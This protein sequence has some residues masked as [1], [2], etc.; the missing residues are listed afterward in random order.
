M[1]ILLGP[2][3]IIFSIFNIITSIQRKE[4]MLVILNGALYAVIAFIL[5][6]N[7]VNT[8]ITSHD[9][10]NYNIYHGGILCSVEYDRTEGDYY[11]ISRTGI[12]VCDE[13]AIPVNSANI[14]SFSRLYKPV[15]IYCSKDT[16]QYW[17]EIT[18]NSK[19]YYLCDSAVKIV[20]DFSDLFLTVLV[21]DII[22]IFFFNLILF[23]VNIARFYSEK[24]NTLSSPA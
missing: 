18:V 1:Y 8:S 20:P 2:L 4:K 12:M 5:I 24:K 15:Q 10:V 21:I 14:S 16:D 6:W 13:I 11:I 19:K 9:S 3:I 22:S 17:T 23:T 7:I